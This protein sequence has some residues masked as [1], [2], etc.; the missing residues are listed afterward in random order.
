MK[1]ILRA[2]LTS[3]DA[4]GVLLDCGDGA[5]MRIV[6]LADDLVRVTL[7]RG[8]ELRQKRTWSV[9]A[10]GSDDTDWAGRVRLNDSSWPAVATEIAATP[11]LCLDRDARPAS[12]R[13]AA[14]LPHGLGAAR[15]NDLHCRDW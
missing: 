15:R 5:M 2:R 10:F 8:G 6:A 7:L 3:S 4:R 13:D 12:H 9:P 11:R 14:S 1:P